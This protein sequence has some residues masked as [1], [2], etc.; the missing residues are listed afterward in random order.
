M[1]DQFEEQIHDIVHVIKSECHGVVLSKRSSSK[2]D[3]HVMI[4]VITED[5]ENWFVS[6]NPGFSSFWFP[7]YITVMKRALK[8][9]K[10]NCDPDMV[11]T[12]GESVK[13]IGDAQTFMQCG[14]K[15]RYNKWKS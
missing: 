7:L 4:T 8:W 13:T 1:S 15:F 5:D 14:W 10:E 6:E 3:N 9:M 12:L 2:E 11:N